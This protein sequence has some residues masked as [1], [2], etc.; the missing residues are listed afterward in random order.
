MRAQELERLKQKDDEATNRFNKWPEVSQRIVLVGSAP[1]DADRIATTP[2]N[3]LQKAINKPNAG[4]AE[5]E[6]MNQMRELGLGDVSFAHGFTTALYNG[7]L[8]CPLG[9]TPGNFN[10]FALTERAPFD[11]EMEER[12]TLLSLKYSLGGHRDCEALA[13]ASKQSVATPSNCF[14]LLA[15]AKFFEG[16]TRI[17][18]ART[19]NCP[20]GY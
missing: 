12:P 2:P 13:A 3:S 4:A 7:N 10:P 15:Q 16:A 9:S 8:A 19:A 6:L 5:S 1:Y 17:V 20:R 11:Q 14:D 18:S